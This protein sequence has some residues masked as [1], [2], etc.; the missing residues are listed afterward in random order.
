MLA[1]PPAILDM[2]HLRAGATV[3]VAVDGGRLVV[4]WW[5]SRIRARATRWTSCWRNATRRPS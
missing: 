1:V 4:V 2:L 3:G 5:S